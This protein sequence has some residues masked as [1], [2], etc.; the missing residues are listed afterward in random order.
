MATQAEIVEA[1]NRYLMPNYGRLPV[2]MARGRGARIW[3]ANG[4]E[5]IDFFAGFG[6]AGAVGHCH[7][8]IVEAVKKQA[9]TLLCH[10][11]L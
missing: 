1:T 9:E 4:K 8:K 10:G 11:N 3:D 6:G 2:A 7:P 5:Y